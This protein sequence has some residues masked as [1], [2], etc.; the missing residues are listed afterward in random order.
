V[1][2]GAALAERAVQGRSGLLTPSSRHVVLLRRC[3]RGQDELM[4]TG[5]EELLG[6]RCLPELGARRDSS[7]AEA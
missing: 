7:D 4:A 6:A 2:I 1:E 3:T 5:S